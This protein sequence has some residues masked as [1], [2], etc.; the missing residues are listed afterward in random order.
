MRSRGAAITDIVVLVVAADDSVMPQTKEAIDHAKAANVPVIVAINK[1]DKVGI[2]VEKVKSD[3]TSLGIIPEEYGGENLFV[4]V[5]AKQKIGIDNLLEAIL[6]VSEMKE[7]KANPNRYAIGT[8]IEAKLD[9]GE[10]PK[11][12]LLIENGTLKFQDFVVVGSSYGKIRKMTN[13][14]Q[15][16]L[17]S[18]GPS[19]P[20]SII[21]LSEV[22]HAGDPFIALDNEK[23]A[24]EIATLRRLVKEDEARGEVQSASIE[25]LYSRLKEQNLQFINVIIKAD[26]TGS[27]EAIRGALEKLDVGG[28]KVNILSHGPGAITEGDIL[29]ASTSDAIVYGFNVRPNAVVQ[30]RA[31]EEKVEIRLHRIIYALIEEMEKALRGQLKVE[32]VEKVNATAEV[33]ETFSASK[34]GTIAGSYITSGVMKNN[35]S[36]RLIRN[37]IVVYEGKI[38]SMKRFKD[39][40][41]EAREGYECGI[42]LEKYN[43]IKQGDIIEGYEMVDKK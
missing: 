14:Q 5:S 11:A 13:D 35:Q 34:L 28:V 43:D 33:R 41:K 8:V 27:A 29:L 1:I 25:D 37:S 24:R 32:K 17:K 19:T 3:L 40:V 10:G 23:T 7:L 4:E 20:V 26:T 9:K 39:D 30:A 42:V 12:T 18:A 22:P 38:S 2:N 16:V 15:K 6:L 21:G 31:L 36:V